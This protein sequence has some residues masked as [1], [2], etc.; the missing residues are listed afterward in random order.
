MLQSLWL[1]LPL[2]VAAQAPAETPS[3]LRSYSVRA[4]A[5]AVLN[6]EGQ[7]VL[8]PLSRDFTG[9]Y[10]F[11]CED[12]ESDASPVVSFLRALDPAQ[13]EYEGRSIDLVD[14]IRLQVL[15]PPALQDVVTRALT[16]LEETVARPTTF[17][18]DVVSFGPNPGVLNLPPLLPISEVARWTAVGTGLETYEFTLRPGEMCSQRAERTMAFA[19]EGSVE[20]AERAAVLTLFPENVGVGTAAC[21]A[22]APGKGGSWLAL[23]LRNGRYLDVD[24]VRETRASSAI[25][26]DQA[27][28]IQELQMARSDVRIANHSLAVNAFVPDGKALAFVMS[29]GLESR[30][31][32]VRQLGATPPLLTSLPEDLKRVTSR[33][34]TTLT[35]LDGI[36][37]PVAYAAAADGSPFHVSFLR[38]RA[39]SEKQE[40]DVLAGI[41][42]T[43]CI[44]PFGILDSPDGEYEVV[45]LG[46]SFALL[47]SNRSAIDQALA[48]LSQLAPAPQ[49][50]V[51]TLTMRRGT[52][53]LSVLCRAVLPLRIGV[54]S[55]LVLGREAVVDIALPAE[56]AQGAT[57]Q[58]PS[59]KS[60]FDGIVL[61]MLPE[62]TAGGGLLLEV[63]AHGRW[64][65]SQPRE[66]QS[67]GA[68]NARVQLPDADE[69]DVGRSV[70]F[71]KSDGTPRK[72]TLGNAGTSDEALTLEI[73][74]VDL[75]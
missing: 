30:V 60:L 44:E 34:A 25:A 20:I 52:R 59:V 69:L 13:W 29:A 42:P 62:A 54:R 72:L 46:A 28:T 36:N 55:S 74:V 65:R 4:A 73:E 7:V 8:A 12:I 40:P 51:A 61:S 70:V 53:D 71:P 75:R 5:P 9:G 16:V 6:M 66:Y 27:V 21:L 47:G 15:A 1:T 58:D 26:H 23:A 32:F 39:N 17:V 37:L 56:V 63:D 24:G 18:V 45:E 38:T 19:L 35:R 57:A 64:S 22:V 67:G 11:G 43:T 68:M 31:V 50:I 49:S 41:Q 48:K 10:P 33:N 3:V 14:A 2:T